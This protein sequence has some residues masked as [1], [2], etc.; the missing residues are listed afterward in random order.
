MLDRGW[1]TIWESIEPVIHDSSKPKESFINALNVIGGLVR[2]DQALFEFL[3]TAPQ[4]MP[5]SLNEGK[6]AWKNYQTK[7]YGVF[8]GLLEEGMAKNEFPQNTTFLRRWYHFFVLGSM[9]SSHGCGSSQ[10]RA[11]LCGTISPGLY[12]WF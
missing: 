4:T 10:H 12:F 5:S 3:F 2:N 1:E 7:M 6:P 9:T 11:V 8:Q